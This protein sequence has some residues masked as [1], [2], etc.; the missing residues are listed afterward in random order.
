MGPER[1]PLQHHTFTTA[2]TSWQVLYDPKYSGQ[3]TV[4]DNPIQIADAALYLMKHQASLKITDPYELT[5]PQFDAA[6]ALLKTQRPLVKKYWGLASQEISLFQNGD[7]ELG[8]A[9]PYQTSTL[10]AANAP[11]NDTIPLRKG[12]PAGPTP[13]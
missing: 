2:P 8:A 3:I 4:P 1:A 13:G 12:P 6:V 5:Q 9:W 11:V 7:V 10:K